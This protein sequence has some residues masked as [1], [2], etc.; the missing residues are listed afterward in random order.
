MVNH[1]ASSFEGALKNGGPAG[2]IYGFIFAWIG[3][4]LQ[5]LVQ[6]EMGSM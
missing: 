2:L 6:G 3:T 1:P 5:A 4:L